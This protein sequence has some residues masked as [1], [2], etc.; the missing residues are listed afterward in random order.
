MINEVFVGHVSIVRCLHVIVVGLELLW[1]DI[2]V[3]LLKMDNQVPHLYL[4]E[5]DHFFVLGPDVL[6]WE[7]LD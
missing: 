4:G 1:V 7:G 6:H 3:V 5:T 2:S